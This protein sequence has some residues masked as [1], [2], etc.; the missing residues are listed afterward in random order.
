MTEQEQKIE[1]KKAH[2][3]KIYDC[4]M[5]SQCMIQYNKYGNF[6]ALEQQYQ[7]YDFRIGQLF[8]FYIVYCLFTGLMTHKDQ[9]LGI[10]FSRAMAIVFLLNEIEMMLYYQKQIEGLGT[11]SKKQELNHNKRVELITSLFP[12]T[13]CVFEKIEVQR[14]VFFFITNVAC[15]VSQIHASDKD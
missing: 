12:P 11:D 7:S 14:L 13:Y 2:L 6:M 10:S 8:L 5:F 1:D 15:L 4:L 3:K 9:A